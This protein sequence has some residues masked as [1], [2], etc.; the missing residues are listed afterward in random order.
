MHNCPWGRLHFAPAGLT[1]ILQTNANTL[2]DPA[3]RSASARRQ[4]CIAFL[5]LNPG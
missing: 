5:S 2:S 1:R 4:E 3:Y